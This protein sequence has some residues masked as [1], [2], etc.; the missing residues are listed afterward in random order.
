MTVYSNNSLPLS[1]LERFGNLLYQFLVIL[2]G[3]YF[4]WG[5][6]IGY[7]TIHICKLANYFV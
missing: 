3:G 5:I 6:A 2:V 7:Y 4:F 1:L